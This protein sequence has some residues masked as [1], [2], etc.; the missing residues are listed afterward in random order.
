MQF[1]GGTVGHQ[2]SMGPGS[3]SVETRSVG[4]RQEMVSQPAQ[5]GVSS[6]TNGKEPVTQGLEALQCTQGCLREQLPANSVLWC[7]EGG[8]QP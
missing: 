6:R 8:V 4:V 5:S 1:G 7:G 2:D 3:R